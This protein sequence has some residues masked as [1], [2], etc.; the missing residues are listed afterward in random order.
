V[1]FVLLDGSVQFVRSE[2][3]KQALF[4]L[5]TRAGDEINDHVE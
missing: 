2:I 4:A 3:E 5:I 1:Q